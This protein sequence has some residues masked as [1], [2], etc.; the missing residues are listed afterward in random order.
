MQLYLVRHAESENNARPAYLRVE[1]PG[2]TA[3]GRLQAQHLADWVRTMA[4][5]HL[6]TS[7]FLRTLQTTR[8]VTDATGAPVSIWDNVYERGGCFRGHGPD[9]TE[10]GIGL[11]R[12]GV[13]RHV[14]AQADRCTVDSSIGEA[15]WWAG[16]PRETDDEAEVRATTVVQRFAETFGDSQ[17]V[18]VAI[19]HADLKRAMLRHML[20]PGADAGL[21]GALRNVGV[22]KLDFSAGT[23]Q[24]DWFNSVTHLPSKL[25]TGNES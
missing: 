18:V 11:G 21:F 15:G 20:A 7:P 19:I 2:I 13:I 16:K 9:A 1:D 8:Y 6:I 10:G 22:T 17:D 14:V 5:D 12:S 23:W 25:I 3:V 4:F 24:L